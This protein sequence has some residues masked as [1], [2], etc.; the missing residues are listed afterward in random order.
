[1]ESIEEIVVARGIETLFHFTRIENLEPI[2][3]HGLMTKTEVELV[4]SPCDSR[5]S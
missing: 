5:Q 3:L 1:M 2:L 4:D